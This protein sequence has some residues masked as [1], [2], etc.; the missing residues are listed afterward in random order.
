MHS[1]QERMTMNKIIEQDVK[2]ILASEIIDWSRFRNTNVLI[3]GANGMLPSYL[4]F[5]LLELSNRGY[6]VNVYALVRN[7][8]KAE[9]IFKDMLSNPCLHF[10]VQD[11][12]API[13]VGTR[14]HYIIHAASQASPKYYGVD[15]VGTITANVQ[16]TINTLELARKNDSVS[17]LY[18]SSGEVYGVFDSP[19]PNVEN[20]YGVID[21]VSVRSCYGQSKRQG[22]NL[23]VCYNYQHHTHAK[24]VRPFHTFG[25]G[26]TL[27]DGRVFADFTKNIL[28]KQDIVLRSKG[29]A[30]R[31]FCYITD[32][33]I[34]Y[35]KVL[36][37][38]LDSEAYNVGSQANALSI[39]ELAETL[40]NLY[41]ELNLKVRIEILEDDLRTVKMKSPQSVSVPDITKLQSLGFTPTI[42]FAE[43]FRRTI[44]SFTLI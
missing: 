42:S 38:G 9:T 43:G 25:P 8:Q 17:Y 21:P 40:V 41:P 5:T 13:N 19:R 23:C 16:G 32:A 27:D 15:P 6:N 12:T 7:R 10:I 14:V 24:I 30:V 39:R 44:E 18:F 35:F 1:V 28:E 37:D 22:E 33:A 2:E 11:V 20:E 3:T 34:A 36:L 26:M 4:V 31:A 29:D